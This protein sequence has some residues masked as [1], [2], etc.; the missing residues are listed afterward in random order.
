MTFSFMT[1]VAVSPTTFHFHTPSL[2]KAMW[3]VPSKIHT[4]S[5]CVASARM[6]VLRSQRSAKRKQMH[7]LT[8]TQSPLQKKT[9]DRVTIMDITMVIMANNTLMAMAMAMITTMAITMDIMVGMA[10]TMDKVSKVS[11]KIKIKGKII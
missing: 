8:Q 4:A 3:R 7:S 2:D 11:D 9:Q 6:R 5:A 10:V 1:G